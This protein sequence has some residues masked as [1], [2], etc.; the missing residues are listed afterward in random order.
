[1]SRATSTALTPGT[2]VPSWI[3]RSSASASAS[4]PFWYSRSRGR[5]STGQSR[6]WD[7]LAMPSRVTRAFA[8]RKRVHGAAQGAVRERIQI[9]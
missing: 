8:A 7:A 1:M 4:A 5:S 6:I 3:A 2:P 9:G